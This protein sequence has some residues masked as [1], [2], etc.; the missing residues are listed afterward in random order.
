MLATLEG[1]NVIINS[2]VQTV[3]CLLALTGMHITLWCIFLQR[4]KCIFERFLNA[5]KEEDSNQT[6]LASPTNNL[7]ETL[8]SRPN[9]N[10]LP[11]TRS[12]A[13]RP[14]FRVSLPSPL[15]LMLIMLNILNFFEFIPSVI[16]VYDAYIFTRF[17][18]YVTAEDWR[19]SLNA[20][21]NTCLCLYVLVYATFDGD[22]REAAS[23]LI[24]KVKVKRIRI[25]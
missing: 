2:L 23:E 18:E 14:Q 22:F 11:V 15:F 25:R 8:A 6:E 3:P 9:S 7:D 21:S 10:P 12:A 17:S 5:Q 20:I 19:Y 13:P 4:P 16:H 1:D 24:C